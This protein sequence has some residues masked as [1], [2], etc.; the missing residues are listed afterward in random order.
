MNELISAI[1]HTHVGQVRAFVHTKPELL[2]QLTPNGQLPLELAKAK[3]HKRIE[4]AIARA[5]DVKA[6]YSA[7]EL[8]QLLV[9]YIADMSEEYYAAGWYDSIECELWALLMG[10]DLGGG[11]Q[12]RWNRLIDPEELADLRFLAEHTQCWAMWNENHHNDPNAEDVLVVA[13]PDWQPM[14]NAWLAKH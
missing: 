5:M 9:D 11:L 8:Q 14:F 2:T 7:A 13:L 6:H 1:L 3:G 12:R 4:T 10:D